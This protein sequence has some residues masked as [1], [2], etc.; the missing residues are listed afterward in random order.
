MEV[1]ECA[2]PKRI[3]LTLGTLGETIQPVGLANLADTVPAAGQN[4]VRI[5]LMA[6]IPD[7]PVGW[8]V[9]DVVQCHSQLNDTQAGAEV[10]T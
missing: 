5:R 1:E 9:V 6:D 3:I 10:P 7:Q 4:L 8:R 2:A